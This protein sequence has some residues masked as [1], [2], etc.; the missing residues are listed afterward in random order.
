MFT[1]AHELHAFV[2][3]DVCEYTYTCVYIHQYVLTFSLGHI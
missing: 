1:E 3:A 2:Y